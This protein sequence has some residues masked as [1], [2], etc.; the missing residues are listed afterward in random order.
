MVIGRTAAGRGVGGDS[1]S[2]LAV[3]L[4]ITALF[5]AIVLGAALVARFEMLVSRRYLAAS[6]AFH[7][8]DAGL[9]A[10]IAELRGLPAWTAVVAGERA[11]AANGGAFPGTVRL[12][13]GTVAVCCGPASMSGRLEADTQRSPRPVR[14]ALRWRPFLWNSLEVL[15]GSTDPASTF[16]VVWIA[17]DEADLAGAASAD[18]NDTVLVRSEAAAPNGVRRAVEA[19]VG[20]PPVPAGGLYSEGS[21]SEEARLMRVG[22]LGWR[23]VR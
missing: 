3:V 1:G 16:V 10:A 8:A 19:V 21:A 5:S 14:R 20:R 17:N 4:L 9:D 6:A 15:S 22:I 12:R 7:A 18:F 11:A 13:G 2:A 23:E